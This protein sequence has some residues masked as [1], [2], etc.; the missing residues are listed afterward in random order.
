MKTSPPKKAKD[1]AWRAIQSRGLVTENA[2]PRV[3]TSQASANMDGLP[4]EGIPTVP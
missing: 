1:A 3:P 2:F 4:K